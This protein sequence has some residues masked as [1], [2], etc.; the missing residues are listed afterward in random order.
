MLEWKSSPWQEQKSRATL[1]VAVSESSWARRLVG[2]LC[3]LCSMALQGAVVVEWDA[4][5]LP[6][7]SSGAAAAWTRSCCSVELVTACESGPFSQNSFGK[8]KLDSCAC[9][10]TFLLSLS[11][12][13]FLVS[14]GIPLPQQGSD[15]PAFLEVS[16]VSVSPKM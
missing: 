15:C 14:W 3:H 5:L 12:L 13:L 1:V 8:S 2:L 16:V 10:F 7:C 4:V 11:P 9:H 6:Q